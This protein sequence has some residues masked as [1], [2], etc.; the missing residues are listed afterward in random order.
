MEYL[1]MVFAHCIAGV[2]PNKNCILQNLPTLDQKV[3]NIRLQKPIC[4]L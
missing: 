3:L 4:Q 1:H 2:L